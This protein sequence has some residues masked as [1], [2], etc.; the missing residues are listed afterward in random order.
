[1]QEIPEFNFKESV[2]KYDG[3]AE[4]DKLVAAA[5]GN[6]ITGRILK[7][8]LSSDVAG[9]LGVVQGQVWK[10]AFPKMIGRNMV[11]VIP[12]TNSSE[13]IPRE[14]RAYAWVGE[15][16]EPDTG[17]KVDFV[18]INVDPRTGEIGSKASWTQSFIEDAAWNVLAWQMDAIGK[19]IARKETEQ[20]IAMY[21]AISN[22]DLA[23]GAEITVTD[24]APTWQQVVDLINAV[25]CEDFGDRIVVA[26]NPHEFGGLMKIQEFASSLYNDGGMSGM[27]GELSPGGGVWQHSKLDNVYF[28]TS[29]AIT[30]S[31]AIDIDNAAAMLLRREVTTK[32]FEVA[33]KGRFGVRGTERI[34]MGVIRSKAVARGTN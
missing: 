19:A 15:G 30:K 3:Q 1:M 17:G 9:A 28:V 2:V 13:K 18:T 8:S 4:W 6:P 29:T 14:M 33:E 10:A 31:L 27:N 21:N 34:G 24:G 26:M 32:Q 11:K 7:E 20:I 5:N 25:Y 22:S 23:T 16:N 12:T